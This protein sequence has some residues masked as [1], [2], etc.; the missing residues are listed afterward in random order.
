MAPATRHAAV[1]ATHQGFI[2]GLNTV[3]VIGGAVALF[4]AVLALWLVREREIERDE[5]AASVPDVS[6]DAFGYA[7]T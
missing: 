7:T 1:G 2:T 4:G 6:Q 5:H 3:L